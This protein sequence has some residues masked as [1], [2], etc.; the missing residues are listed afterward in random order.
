MIEEAINCKELWDIGNGVTCCLKC[1][2]K[3]EARIMKGN[4]NGQRN[5]QISLL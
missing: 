5:R 3:I 4:K 1:H 2:K